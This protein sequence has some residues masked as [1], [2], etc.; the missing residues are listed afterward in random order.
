MT[1]FILCN[2]KPQ[3]QPIDEAIKNRLVDAE[4][5]SKFVT[6]TNEIDE[7][8]HIYKANNYFETLE[9]QEK[10][11]MDMFNILTDYLKK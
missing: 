3:I 9:F 1:I 2:S 4:F 11:K 8:S 7:Q 6:N 5:K 10:Y